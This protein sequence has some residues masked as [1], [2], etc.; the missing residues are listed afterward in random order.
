MVVVFVIWNA[1]TS[2][3][4]LGERLEIEQLERTTEYG[5]RTKYEVRT[6]VNKVFSVINRLIAKG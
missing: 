5:G 1:Y 6:P 4:L 3:N 2:F